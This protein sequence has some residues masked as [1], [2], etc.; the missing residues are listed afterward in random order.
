MLLD[1]AQNKLTKKLGNKIAPSV[2]GQK[3]VH[4]TEVVR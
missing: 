1:V 3:A 4:F 2:R